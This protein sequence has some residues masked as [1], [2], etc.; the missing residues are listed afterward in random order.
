MKRVNFSDKAK[1]LESTAPQQQQQQQQ[2]QRKS[3]TPDL[4][5]RSKAHLSEKK[6][7]AELSPTGRMRETMDESDSDEKIPHSEPVVK[8]KKSSS[9]DTA[10]VEVDQLASRLLDAAAKKSADKLEEELQWMERKGLRFDRPPLA[11]NEHLKKFRTTIVVDIF[12]GCGEKISENI[13]GV[14]SRLM[15]LGCDPN[16]ADDSGN[17][18]LMLA[19]KAGHKNLMMFMINHCPAIKLHAVNCDGRNAAM[20]ASE[21][22]QK[23]LLLALDRAGISLFPKNP[24]ITFYTLVQHVK[25]ETHYSNR[26]NIVLKHLQQGD[27]LNLVD[28]SGKTLLMHATIQGDVEMIKALLHIGLGPMVHIKD[29]HGMDVFAH[30]EALRNEHLGE[31]IKKM[32][33]DNLDRY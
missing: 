31:Q 17:T 16:S 14:I 24:A 28:E 4:Q 22:G 27:Y 6:K 25:G 32:I 13:A 23:H 2:T 7:K 18:P 19:C 30:A 15:M 8:Q 21:A 29:V 11:A 1:E 12:R 3:E 9:A 33:Y 20:V 10:S 5:P 26:V